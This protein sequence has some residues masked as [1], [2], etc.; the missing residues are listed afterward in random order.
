M[1]AKH[2][3]AASRNIAWAPTIDYF[4]DGDAPL[5][6]EGASIK[7]EVRLYPGAPDGAI[8]TIN[9]IPFADLDVFDGSAQRRLRLF[10]GLGQDILAAFPTGL[11]QPEPGEADAFAYDIVITYADLQQDKLALG[12]FLLE[13][14]VTLP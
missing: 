4:Y 7:M 1:T 5:P 9:D 14:G 13:P 11:N 6:L 3:L 10:P 2:D 12:R 8:V